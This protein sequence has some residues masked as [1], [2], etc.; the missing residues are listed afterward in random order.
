MDIEV[1]YISFGL[2]LGVRP[3]ANLAGCGKVGKEC[4]LLT[5]RSRLAVGLPE[6][7]GLVVVVGCKEVL[8]V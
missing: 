2:G 4:R 1:L 5:R 8:R 3:N 6:L 7:S